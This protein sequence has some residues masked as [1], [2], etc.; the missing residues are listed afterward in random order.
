M[1][2]PLSH[3]QCLLLFVPLCTS[4]SSVFC[5]LQRHKSP[6]RA[7]FG[8]WR[9]RQPHKGA[10]KDPWTHRKSS[11]WTPRTVWAPT[12]P[13]FW[14]SNVHVRWRLGLTLPLDVILR[15]QQTEASAAGAG[16][17]LGGG[18]EGRG[19]QGRGWARPAAAP[20]PTGRVQSQPGGTLLWAAPPAGAQWPRWGNHTASVFQPWLIQENAGPFSKNVTYSH[21]AIPREHPGIS[22]RLRFQDHFDRSDSGT[23]APPVV[24]LGC[25][26][27]SQLKIQVELLNRSFYHDWYELKSTFIEQTCNIQTEIQ[28]LMFK[29]QIYPNKSVCYENSFFFLHEIGFLLW[30]KMRALHRS[31]IKAKLVQHQWKRFSSPPSHYG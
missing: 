21:L 2:Y 20:G 8:L 24:K 22:R 5:L 9:E 17:E 25:F 11:S 18:P 7:A 28:T 31:L 4:S 13:K 12:Q 30:F 19:P 15:R 23:K 26:T 10:E 3:C 29:T 1:L 16:A 14:W 27:A 6:N